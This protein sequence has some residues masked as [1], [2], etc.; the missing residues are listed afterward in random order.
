MTDARPAPAVLTRL[1]VVTVPDGRIQVQLHLQDRP[2]VRRTMRLGDRLG[3][4]FGVGP[5]GVRPGQ[6]SEWNDPPLEDH[7]LVPRAAAG[8][9]ASG[10]E[11]ALEAAAAWDVGLLAVGLAH[12][13]LVNPGAVYVQAVTRPLPPA[14]AARLAAAVVT[15]AGL[16]LE[17]RPLELEVHQELAAPE[18]GPGFVVVRV[19]L[20]R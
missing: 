10:V 11:R 13:A 12:T 4:T 2:P 9:V 17:G 14:H 7:G 15:L 8:A 1:E 20:K 16:A 6:A 5:G 18:E 3:F 19:V